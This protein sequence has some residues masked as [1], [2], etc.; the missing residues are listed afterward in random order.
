MFETG[1]TFDND[2]FGNRPGDVYG[3]TP[4]DVYGN[5]PSD[6]FG[7]DT[8]IGDAISGAIDWFFG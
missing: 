8:T 4:G 3:N 2:I 6:V 7:N 1:D 5:G